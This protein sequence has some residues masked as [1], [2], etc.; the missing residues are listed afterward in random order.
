MK[1]FL[2]VVMG[3]CI[4][5]ITGCG[6]EEDKIMKCS[7]TI[8]QSNIRMDLSYNITYNGDYVIKVKSKEKIVSNDVTTLNTYKEQLENTTASF[9]DIKHYNHTITIDGN[10]LIS[11]INI[12]YSKVDTD[13]LIEIDSSMK[14]IIKD[15]K[16]LV[17][18]I[19]SLYGQLGITCKK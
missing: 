9:K 2:L 8:N 10:T 4:F 15:G 1:K 6:T 17:S 11:S 3:I 16:I 14:Q 18:D 12:D 7:H 13:K 19:E 5:L